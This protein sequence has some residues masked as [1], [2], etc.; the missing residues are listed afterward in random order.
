M[1]YDL[2]TYPHAAGFKERTTSREAALKMKHRQ[3]KL[4]AGVLAV[5]LE[6][7][8]GGLTTDECAGL[9]GRSVLSI[10]PRFTEL[11]M[12][13]KIHRTD[14]RRKN[15]SGCSAIVWVATGEQ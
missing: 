2:F 3:P 14:R 10:R 6:A 8:A 7:G 9:M 15:E 1:T 5:L 13:G 12:L 4:S 11:S